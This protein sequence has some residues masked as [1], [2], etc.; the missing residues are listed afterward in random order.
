MGD[1]ART[2]NRQRFIW[3]AVVTN[4]VGLLT[5]PFLGLLSICLNGRQAF[6]FAVAILV[7]GHFV[8][9]HWVPGSLRRE[10]GGWRY[11][12]LAAVAG[13]VGAGLSLP[14]LLSIPPMCIGEIAIWRLLFLLLIGSWAVF[15]SGM[16]LAAYWARD[17]DVAKGSSNVGDA[18]ARE[19]GSI[20][21]D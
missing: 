17:E 19:Q 3:L 2:R 1:A 5:M 14:F 7:G 10:L 9:Y 12:V 4:G 8:A 18:E 16:Q 6:V 15:G 11:A 21:T 13:C 20:N